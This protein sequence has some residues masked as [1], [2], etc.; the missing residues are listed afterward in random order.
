MNTETQKWNS[1]HHIGSSAFETDESLSL[2]WL[3][4]ELRELYFSVD[5]IMQSDMFSAGNGLAIAHQNPHITYTLE[6]NFR[7]L[8]E[9]ITLQEKEYIKIV[10]E[11]NILKQQYLKI[12]KVIF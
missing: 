5:M 3:P 10:T 12:N 7:D 8:K 11:S 9:I 4:L 6:R 2:L 1:E